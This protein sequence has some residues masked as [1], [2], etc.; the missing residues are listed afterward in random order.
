M[1]ILL[2]MDGVLAD[3][4]RAALL[5]HEKLHLL[6]NWP[7]GEWNIPKVLGISD[8]EFWQVIDANID[9]WLGIKPLPWVR[10][11]YD[12]CCEFGNVTIS[13]SPSLNST[14]ASHKIIW[15]REE[16]KDPS[17]TNYMIGSNK[18]L[19]SREGNIL[20]DDSYRNCCKFVGAGAGESILFPA[21]TNSAWE[22]AEHCVDHVMCRLEDYAR[23]H[24]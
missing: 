17:F 14:C 6:D 19:M 1:N 8:N 5:E 9:F 23:T 10:E 21:I 13:T 12:L 22:Y 11:L 2:D 20:I 15:L 16:L 24:A 18:S 3:F 4:H 7:K